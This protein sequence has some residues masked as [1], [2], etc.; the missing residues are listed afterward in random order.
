MQE[1]NK[2]EAYKAVGTPVDLGCLSVV[3]RLAVVT[4]SPICRYPK[5]LK[6]TVESVFKLLWNGPV[7]GDRAVIQM[8]AAFL[9]VTRVWIV[10]VIIELIALCFFV[11]LRVRL[12]WAKSAV[13]RF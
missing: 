7:Q 1:L 12:I 3:A 10:V 8:A 11:S 9:E 4:L 13:A 2:A 6:D 5:E